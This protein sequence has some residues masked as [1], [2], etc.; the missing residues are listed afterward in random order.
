[1]QKTRHVD[2]S[3]TKFSPL[4]HR[5]NLSAH[6]DPHNTGVLIVDLKGREG[7]GR[8]RDA[9]MVVDELGGK[10]QECVIM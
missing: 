10:G 5:Y 8:S 1:M 6:V 7:A 9:G 2:E 4:A 3:G